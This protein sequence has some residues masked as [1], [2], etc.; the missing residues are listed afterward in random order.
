MRMESDQSPA[1]QR[2]RNI[3][4][5]PD[6]DRLARKI[7]MEKDMNVSD[8]LA[9]LIN[10]E[11]KLKRGTAHLYASKPKLEEVAA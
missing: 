10:K 2:R 3:S 4:W 11:A 6:I 7:A 5:H 8:L 9:R 1:P